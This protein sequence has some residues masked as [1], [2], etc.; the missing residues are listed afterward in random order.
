MKINEKIRQIRKSAG[1]TQEQ[2]ANAITN[3]KAGKSSGTNNW[4]FTGATQISYADYIASP[5]TYNDKCYI[6]YDYNQCDAFFGG[7][8]DNKT[9]I[10]YSTT[11]YE[12]TLKSSKTTLQQFGFINDVQANVY[13]NY[14]DFGQYFLV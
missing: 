10:A 12:N 1:L 6:I 8:H 5:D 14:Y 9:T 13:Y 11:N 3:F 2:L 7:N 4:K